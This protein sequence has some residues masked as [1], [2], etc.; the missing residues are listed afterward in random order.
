[1]RPFVALI[2]IA[3]YGCFA[4]S[5]AYASDASITLSSGSNSAISGAIS[6]LPCSSAGVV[7]T[8]HF[9][10]PGMN[11]VQSGPQTP[12]ASGVSN[13][14]ITSSYNP[15]WTFVE[16]LADSTEVEIILY[17]NGQQYRVLIDGVEAINSGPDT[18]TGMATAGDWNTITLPS[19]A[20]A[21]DGAYNTQ[22]IFI[23]G[24]TGSGQSNQISAYAG[25]TRVAT[26]VDRW[27]IEP[28]STSQFRV[29]VYNAPFAMPPPD[30]LPYSMLFTF[31]GHRANRHFRIETDNYFSGIR[32]DPGGAISIPDSVP[33]ARMFLL[34]DSFG[35][36]TG[37]DCEG[38]GFGAYLADAFGWEL[39]NISSGG[40]GMVN[41][42]EPGSGR[43]RYAD[44]VLPPVNS[45]IINRWGVTAAGTFTLSQGSVTTAPIATSATYAA[46]QSSL[47]AS[48]GTNAWLA[49]IHPYYGFVILGL[50]TNATSTAPLTLTSDGVTGSVSVQRYL[51]DI[52]P[53]VPADELGNAS[54]FYILVEGS[55]GDDLYA[56]ELEADARVLYTGLAAK[57]PTAKIIATG[58]WMNQGPETVAAR[59]TNSALQA[60]SSALPFI[61]NHSPFLNLFSTST[62]VG[63]L[64]GTTNIGAPS[65]QP[66]I[67]T[68][69]Y[70]YYD[71]THPTVAGHSYLAKIISDG[72]F[73]IVGFPRHPVPSRP[74]TR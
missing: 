74:E 46:L 2:A 37:A 13:N 53:F 44:R 69:V 6:F 62:G 36:G 24:G 34:G 28:D 49:G 71:G 18:I 58:R 42:G 25:S 7:D 26:V 35:E 8:T 48:F 39:W 29:T 57:F 1:M 73:S 9:R 67:N 56:S 43:F 20:S 16:T 19:S 15:G 22:Q 55:G 52:A 40:T 61:D 41:A 66:G 14:A 64:N 51:G 4:T 72:L 30:G 17:G 32:V 65:G 31:G 60:A 50:G 47:D 3:V 63:Y 38:H 68:D 54:E 59:A 23:T 5:Q 12:R 27:A 11:P 45:W 10:Y 21:T 33:N 70:V